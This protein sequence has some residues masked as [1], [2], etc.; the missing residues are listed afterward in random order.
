[1]ATI[2]ANVSYV[3]GGEAR[4]VIW[5]GLGNADTGTAIQLSNFPKKTIDIRGTFGSA[6]V[7][8]QGSM[9]GTNWVTLNDSGGNALSFT[10]ASGLKVILENPKH[11][12][13]STSGGTGTDLDAIMTATK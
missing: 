3:P 13:V 6:T 2:T 10:S 4:D 1:M 12:R 8:V 9:D 5:E 7:V 11:I